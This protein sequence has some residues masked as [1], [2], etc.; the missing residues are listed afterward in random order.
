MQ[1][2][3][4]VFLKEVSHAPQYHYS[5]NPDIHSYFRDINERIRRYS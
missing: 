1:E 3:Y 2:K 5:I 4:H